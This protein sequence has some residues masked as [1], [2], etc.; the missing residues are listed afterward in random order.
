MKTVM[1]PRYYC[2]FCNKGSG[3]PSH[4]KRHEAGCTIRPDRRCGMCKAAR[5]EQPS[6]QDL[7]CAAGTVEG[8]RE[9]AKGCPACMLAAIR[10]TKWPKKWIECDEIGNGF[11]T[12]EI[13]EEI[14]QWKFKDAC[15]GWWAEVNEKTLHDCGPFY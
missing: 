10:Q 12:K 15:T 6:L 3:S 4:M 11:W 14:E 7:L 5:V 8:L 2:E 1:R 9:A 13:P